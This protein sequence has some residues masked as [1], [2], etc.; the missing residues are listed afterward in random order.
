MQSDPVNSPEKVTLVESDEVTNAV[1][2]RLSPLIPETVGVTDPPLYDVGQLSETDLGVIVTVS[3]PYTSSYP[4][5][6]TL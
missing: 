5:A 3:L 2:E 4:S 6:V 1:A